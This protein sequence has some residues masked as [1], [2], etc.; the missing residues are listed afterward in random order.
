VHLS[1]LN[2]PI[3]GDK[4]YGENK[5]NNINQQTD[6]HLLH[7]Y[8]VQFKHPISG[9]TIEIIAPIPQDIQKYRPFDKK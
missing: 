2:C 5:L 4:L 6:R 9:K 1:S 7:A 3:I 8:S